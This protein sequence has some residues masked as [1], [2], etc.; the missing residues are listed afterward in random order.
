MHSNANGKISQGYRVQYF[1]V[2]RGCVG[3]C[4]PDSRVLGEQD[5]ANVPFA[6]TCSGVRATKVSNSI[7]SIKQNYTSIAEVSL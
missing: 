1:D 6:A 2:V 5:S 4:S 3:L 7:D